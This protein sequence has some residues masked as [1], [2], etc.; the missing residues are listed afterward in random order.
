VGGRRPVPVSAACSI[1]GEKAAVASLTRRSQG[2]LVHLIN[3]CR[4]DAEFGGDRV[5]RGLGD[6]WVYPTVGGEVWAYVA[7]V[8]SLYFITG[9][10]VEEQGDVGLG[11]SLSYWSEPK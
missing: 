1:S 6:V 2:G 3:G 9:Q 10:P 5:D 7:I 4:G 8:V 11:C